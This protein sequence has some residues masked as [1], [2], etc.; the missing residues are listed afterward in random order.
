MYG[1]YLMQLSR[2]AK[3]CA[4]YSDLLFLNSYIAYDS[5]VRLTHIKLIEVVSDSVI[6][7]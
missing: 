7:E 6:D 3:F 1:I 5:A 2:S 4:Y